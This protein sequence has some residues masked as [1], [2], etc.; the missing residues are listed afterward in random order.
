MNSNL[1]QS[2]AGTQRLEGIIGEPV[3]LIHNKTHWIPADVIEFNNHL[4]IKD[5]LTAHI[6][7][8]I[9]QNGQKNTLI[10]HSAGNQDARK[11]MMVLA[12]EN[13]YLDGNIQLLSL[14][15]PISEQV[16]RKE[17]NK[18]GATL[19]GQ[20]NHPDD[21]ITQLNKWGAGIGLAAGGGAVAGFNWGAT[22]GMAVAGP[23]GAFIGGFG[24]AVV[25]AGGAAATGAAFVYK[26][27]SL[28]QY[29]DRNVKGVRDVIQSLGKAES[30]KGR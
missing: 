17:A 28:D 3:A 25:G 14:G 27:H 23:Y 30:E 10:L 5:A 1:K 20:Y 7:Y 22:A 9:A 8:M 16:L 6:F 12:L 13:K 26:N 21:P 2:Q 11:A 19:V 18:V 15:S 24:G 29:L 4:T